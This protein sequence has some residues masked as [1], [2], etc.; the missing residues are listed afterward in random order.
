MPREERANAGAFTAD[1]RESTKI[2][3][4]VGSAAAILSRR[5]HAED[6]VL[7]GQRR[8]LIVEL[9]FE[10]TEFLNGTDLFAECIHVGEEFLAVGRGHDGSFFAKPRAAILLPS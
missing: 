2:G 10:I 1:A 9:V 7:A 8:N 6:V 5:Q 3:D 4:G